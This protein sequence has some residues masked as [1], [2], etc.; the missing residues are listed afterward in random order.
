MKTTT[1]KLSGPTKDRFFKR[2]FQEETDLPEELANRLADKSSS[3]FSS[4]RVRS[5]SKTLRS[6]TA[7]LR[8]VSARPI[9]TPD[10][11]PDKSTKK[12]A[13]KAAP[14]KPTETSQSA[15]PSPK[16]AQASPDAGEPARSQTEETTFD[17]YAFGLVPTMQREGEDGLRIKLNAITTPDNLRAMAK[18]Q[19]I[20]LPRELR[21]GDAPTKALRDAI[22]TAVTKRIGDRRSAASE[23]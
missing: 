8:K 17:P 16:P 21:K 6:N 19:Q 10:S 1:R 13:D 18:A 12:L 7:S 2:F 9:A 22:I 20:V 5:G 11:T 15:R 23:A 3:T 4:I 14:K